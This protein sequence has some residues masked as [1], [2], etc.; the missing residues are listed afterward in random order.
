VPG[1]TIILL[2]DRRRGAAAAV[3]AGRGLTLSAAAAAAATGSQ[4]RRPGL[5]QS[6]VT[7]KGASLGVTDVT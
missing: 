2:C 5:R 6:S 7:V 1:L 4:W 3:A